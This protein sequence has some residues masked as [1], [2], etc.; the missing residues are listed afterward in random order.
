MWSWGKVVSHANAVQK[1]GIWT[2]FLGCEIILGYGCMNL[3]KIQ[4][5]AC[6]SKLE[7]I[8]MF[9]HFPQ[10]N[11]FGTRHL[12]AKQLVGMR[13]LIKNNFTKKRKNY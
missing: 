6:K 10:Q 8:A 2:V 11:R 3:I 7:R 1:Q 5:T 13:C 4:I 9:E 12:I